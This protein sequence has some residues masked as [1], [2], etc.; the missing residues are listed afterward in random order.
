MRMRTEMCGPFL[1]AEYRMT[2]LAVWA[3]R[4]VA[5]LIIIRIAL[6]LFSK[7]QAPWGKGPRADQRFDAKDKSVEDG[8]FKE[9]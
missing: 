2:A 4:L 9:L 7:R 3:I 5:L 1:L 8:D 6:F